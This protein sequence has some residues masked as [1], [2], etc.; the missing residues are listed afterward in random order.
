MVLSGPAAWDG[1]VVSFQL[2]FFFPIIIIK[3][4]MVQ[5]QEPNFFSRKLLNATLLWFTPRLKFVMLI[6]FA[7]W[8]HVPLFKLSSPQWLWGFWAIWTT[9]VMRQLDILTYFVLTLCSQTLIFGLQSGVD[10][11][12]VWGWKIGWLF[13][14]VSALFLCCRLMQLVSPKDKKTLIR[15]YLAFCKFL[16]LLL[17]KFA[18]NCCVLSLSLFFF[19]EWGAATSA[20]R[21]WRQGRV[22]ERNW[23]PQTLS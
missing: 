22:R 23:T 7:V 4:V 13:I 5:I 2:R 10:L 8:S 17:C 16:T 6:R 11:G 20:A 3:V 14:C 19:F 1:I 21:K 15:T 9:L 12:R 18:P